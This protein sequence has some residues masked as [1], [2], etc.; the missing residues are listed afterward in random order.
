MK[1]IAALVVAL[2]A[3]LST[4]QAVTWINV[5]TSIT[6]LQGGPKVTKTTLTARSYIMEGARRNGDPDLKKYFIGFRVDT[7]EVSVVYLPTETV[8]YRVV[9]G[10]TQ[11]GNA[12]NGTGTTA[13]ITADATVSS[14]N[15]DF[16]G[17]FYDKVTRKVDGSV[18][19]VAR[20]VFGGNGTQTITGTIRASGKRYEL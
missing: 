11:T 20:T 6:V 7:G 12:A 10:I 17:G 3:L 2:L 4:S 18:S 16:A 13:T 14:I 5:T 8:V 15:T 9:S 19:S 1:H